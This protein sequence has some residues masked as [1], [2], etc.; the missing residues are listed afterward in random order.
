[1]DLMCPSCGLRELE[2]FHFRALAPAPS[3]LLDARAP[4]VRNN[5]Q[6]SIELWQHLRGCQ[7]W[8]AITRDPATGEIISADALAN[9]D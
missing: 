4:Y 5:G 8:I 7:T 1:M 9:H 6:V 2:E 3:V